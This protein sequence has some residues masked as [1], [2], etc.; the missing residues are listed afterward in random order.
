MLGAVR[1]WYV[2]C[3]PARYA[4]L[5]SGGIRTGRDA[6]AAIRSGAALV[7]FV[8]ALVYQGPSLARRINRELAAVLR[9][10]GFAGVRDAIGVDAKG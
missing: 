1:D 4:L 7:Q 5:A 8:T 2:R 6:Y 10:D 9:A 3:D